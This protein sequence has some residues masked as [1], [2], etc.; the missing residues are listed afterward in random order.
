MWQ[1]ARRRPATPRSDLLLLRLPAVSCA[2]AA[3]GVLATFGYDAVS[4]S[5]GTAMAQRRLTS[6]LAAT[7]SGAIQQ[8]VGHAQLDSVAIPPEGEAFALLRVPRF[9][10]GYQVAIVEGVSHADLA[11]GPGHYPNSA[12]P[13]AIGNFA[14]AGHRGPPGEPFNDINRLVAGDELIVETA[15]SRFVYRVTGHAIVQPTQVDVVA[16]VPRHPGTAPVK[17]VMTLTACHPRM[18][19]T[20]RWVTWATLVQSVPKGDGQAAPS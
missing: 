3:A 6:H 9:G 1:R 17:A 2:L 20:Q 16:P 18:S 11:K 13:G 14:V 15:R 7:W 12:V 4:A 19:G 8:P 10:A 5:A